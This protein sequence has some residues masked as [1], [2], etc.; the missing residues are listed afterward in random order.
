[1]PANIVTI[2]RPIALKDKDS[3]KQLWRRYLSFYSTIRDDALYEFTFQRLADAGHR[4]M[5]AFVAEQQGQLVGLVNCI[6]HDH[7]WYQE[8]VVYLQDLYVDE[9]LRGQGIGRLLIEKVYARADET[10]KAGVYW[11][12]QNSNQT[13]MALYDKVAR[14]TDFIK[15]QR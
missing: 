4:D 15:Y 5:F 3:W 8:Q 14:K 13:A 6:I 7:G 2:I 11:M 1:M 9:S 10:G 12:T